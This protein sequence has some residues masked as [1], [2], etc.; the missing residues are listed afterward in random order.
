MSLILIIRVFVISIFCSASFGQDSISSSN[1]LY[2]SQRQKSMSLA[3]SYQNFEVSDSN[4]IGLAFEEEGGF[5]TDFR[6]YIYKNLFLGYTSGRTRFNVINQS[7]VGNYDS[8]ELR[9]RFLHIG[10]EFLPLTNLRLALNAAIYGEVRFQNKN[11]GREINTDTGNVHSFGVGL[12]YEII[13]NLYLFG[14]YDYRIINTN[15]AVPQDVQSIFEKATYNAI[16]FGIKY[17]VGNKDL[18]ETLNIL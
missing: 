12:E 5:N 8:T 2:D 11:E 18:L 4:F 7:I 6:I 3:V 13:K 10:Y 17:T 16:N 9:E 15:I 14:R 1:F